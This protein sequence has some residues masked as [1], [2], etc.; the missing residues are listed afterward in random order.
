MGPGILSSIGVGVWRKAP[1]A[2]PDSNTTLDTFHSSIFDDFRRGKSIQNRRPNRILATSDR[3]IQNRR[4]SATIVLLLWTF[5]KCRKI[6]QVLCV[7]LSL[8]FSVVCIFFLLHLHCIELALAYMDTLQHRFGADGFNR[9][10]TRL[11]DLS[12]YALEAQQ[13]Y[14]S[15]RAILVAIVSQNSFV[16]AFVGYRTIIAR[17]VAKWGIA[18][19][20]LCEIKYQGGVSHHFGGMLTSL[21]RYRAIWGIAAI[22]SQYRAIWG[23]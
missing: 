15:Y 1:E 11:S 5:F 13:R 17:Y 7:R 10:S 23:R 8:E 6:A 14:F 21:K 3:T 16:L 12:G 19:M 20:C 18:Q 22:V 2:Y 4:F 9:T